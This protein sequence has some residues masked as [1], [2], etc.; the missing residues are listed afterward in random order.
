LFSGVELTKNKLGDPDSSGRRKPLAIKG[1]EK[2]VEFDTLIVAISEDSGVDSIGPVKSSK[3]EIANN[4]TVK[5]DQQTMQTSRL[6]VFAAGDVVSGPKTVVEAIAAGKKSAIVID[7]YLKGEKLIHAAAL[8]L[9]NIYIEPAETSDDKE[10]LI[11]RVETPRASVDWRKRNFAEVEVGLS[12][13][14]A[15]KEAKRCLRCD[16][17]FTKPKVE[18]EEA[19]AG[20]V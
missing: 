11:K 12:Q 9:P 3:I 16:L 1:T 6:G 8:N 10:A 19:S 20:G 5:I 14:E 18:Y 13:G 2:C 7:N 17:E 4:N 15:I